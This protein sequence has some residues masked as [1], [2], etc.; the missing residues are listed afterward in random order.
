MMVA[1]ASRGFVFAHVPRTGG[2]SVEAAL[3]PFGDADIA[4]NPGTG[5]ETL[6]DFLAR[7]PALRGAFKFAFV[8]NPWDRAVSFYFHARQRLAPT[9]PQMQAVEGFEDMLQLMDRGVAWVADLLS[10]RPQLRFLSGTDGALLPDFI[11]RFEQLE[12]DFAAACRRVDLVPALARRNASQ[13]GA[14]AAYYS[15]WGRGFVASRYREDIHAF[16]YSFEASP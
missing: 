2:T 11:G 8:R 14:Y 9:L 13:R 4:V 7:T 15:D 16:G 5:H 1:S 3:R 12:Q 10:L 6:G